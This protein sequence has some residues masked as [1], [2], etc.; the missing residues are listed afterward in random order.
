M[1]VL[2][3]YLLNFFIYL[4]SATIL[5]YRPVQSSVYTLYS[6]SSLYSSSLDASALATTSAASESAVSITAVEGSKAL[7][8]CYVDVPAN[9]SVDLILWFRGD[10]ESALY[11]V[12][13]RGGR[14]KHFPSDE[15]S[16]RAFIDIS[17]KPTNLV[18]EPTRSDDAGHY[19][20]RV[21]EF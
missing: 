6:S 3:S 12:D 2:S 18:L 16:A 4:T 1:Q 9:D 13:A 17:S 8:P 11:S 5:F 14:A 21:G 10:G 19:K 7:L 15:L 20:C